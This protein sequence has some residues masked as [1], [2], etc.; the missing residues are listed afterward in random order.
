MRRPGMRAGLL[1]L[2][3]GKSVLDE[4]ALPVK[5]DRPHG[6]D[7]SPSRDYVALTL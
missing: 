2:P 3:Y 6:L 5:G 1:A 7:S 4:W